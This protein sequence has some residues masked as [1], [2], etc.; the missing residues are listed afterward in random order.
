VKRMYTLPQSFFRTLL[1][2]R[3]RLQ[4]KP[5]FGWWRF[6][7]V[8]GSPLGRQDVTVGTVRWSKRG[9]L[10][11][12]IPP[13]CFLYDLSIFTQEEG[14]ASLLFFRRD[15]KVQKYAQ[16]M[17][18]IAPSSLG[19]GKLLVS[20]DVRHEGDGVSF[21]PPVSFSAFSESPGV[22]LLCTCSAG[23]SV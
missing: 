18:D 15:Q 5:T 14:R 11:F 1:P 20:G 13:F 12:N 7:D 8:L 17:R 6:P 16:V 4:F 21:F 10:S 9:D 2:L 22:R 19:A 23:P 3:R